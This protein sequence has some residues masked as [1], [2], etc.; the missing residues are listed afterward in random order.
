MSDFG[1]ALVQTLD[2]PE[3]TLAQKLIIVDE[4]EGEDPDL[5]GLTQDQKKF[6]INAAAEQAL[7][8]RAV[9]VAMAIQEYI[10]AKFTQY[11]VERST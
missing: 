6:A 4:A 9:M 1:D 5:E 8:R 10:E 3:R 11:G 2:E 7:A